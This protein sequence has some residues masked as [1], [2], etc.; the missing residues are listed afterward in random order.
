MDASSEKSFS[1]Q[2]IEIITSKSQ[3]NSTLHLLP[4]KVE[5]VS[6]EGVCSAKVT[7]FF[8]TVQRLSTETVTLSTANREAH[9]VY[10][11][12]FRGR[13]LKGVR[14]SVP[15]HSAGVVLKEINHS[16]QNEVCGLICLTD[17]QVHNLKG[18]I[19]FF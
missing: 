19:I 16:S 12:T 5:C 6:E 7:D 8:T 2:P 18:L 14:V 15:D 13:G 1:S 9:Q 4:C 10:T 3:I 11:A 17:L